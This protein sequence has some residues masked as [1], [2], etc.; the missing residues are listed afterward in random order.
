MVNTVDNSVLS[1]SLLIKTEGLGGEL[2]FTAPP[3]APSVNFYYK[4]PTGAIYNIGNN[5]T[6][7]TIA[8]NI[9]N[10]TGLNI[11]A[12]NQIPP[13]WAE[14]N[15]NSLAYIANKPPIPSPYTLP[16]ATATV[17][18]GIKVGSG[19][20]VT[21]DGLLSV[22]QSAQIPVAT[23]TVLGGVTIPVASSVSVTGLGAIDVKVVT[24]STN[25]IN[26]DGTGALFALQA[27]S[28]QAGVVQIGSGIN[29]TTSASGATIISVPSTPSYTLPV[30][31]ATSLGG[32][33]A[34]NRPSTTSFVTGVNSTT[35]DLQFQE[36]NT[37]SY[38]LPPTTSNSLGGV[39][40]GNNPSGSN[41]FIRG[42][43]ASGTAQYANVAF[44]TTSNFSA[45]RG[46]SLS[47]ASSGV[48]TISTPAVLGITAV[49][50]LTVT[51]TN[52]AISMGLSTDVTLS[53]V[54]GRLG[55][56]LLCAS[57]LSIPISATSNFGIS[58]K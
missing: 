55:T 52:D 20:S 1:G 45:G 10:Q 41:S 23:A 51:G 47:S 43:D 31:T 22:N 13:D 12:I 7:I 48:I 32:I 44:P 6:A 18:G 16:P 8:G 11:Y 26:K 14:T 46:I 34:T 53:V 29:T 3:N 39:I 57:H 38:T 24:A 25:A 54:G 19:L 9:V 27:T 21:A 50:P 28:T 58:C 42:F 35:G 17:L 5:L 4:D 49:A 40:A 33:K 15:P 36:V 37:T 30:A 2:Y 56:N